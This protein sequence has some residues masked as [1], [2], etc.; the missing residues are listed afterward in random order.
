MNKVIKKNRLFFI[1]ILLHLL[2][3]SF[4]ISIAYDSSCFSFR[5]IVKSTILTI[6]VFF[7]II[8]ENPIMGL[9]LI[10]ITIAYIIIPIFFKNKSL[11]IYIDILIFS[12]L[13][14]EFIVMCNILFSL[15]FLFGFIHTLFFVCICIF[16]IMQYKKKSI[17]YSEWRV[18]TKCLSS[19]SL[20]IRSFSRSMIS[21]TSNFI[22][23]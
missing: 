12:L 3:F 19:G 7:D 21:T 4:F 18:S 6:P 13:S 14:V 8:K 5:C 2:E 22:C 1:V 20:A 17:F 10:I 15:N 11:Y 23:R 9:F 16:R